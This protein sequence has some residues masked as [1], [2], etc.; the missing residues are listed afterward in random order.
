[1]ERL[2]DRIQQFDRQYVR[3]QVVK[4]NNILFPKLVQNPHSGEG[5]MAGLFSD[6]SSIA[7]SASG[8]YTLV[9]TVSAGGTR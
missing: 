7:S 3:L 8:T 1:M 9:S 5:D 6:T 2:E 4:K